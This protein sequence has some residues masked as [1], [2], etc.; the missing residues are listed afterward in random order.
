MRQDMITI[1]GLSRRLASVIRVHLVQIGSSVPKMVAAMP[2]DSTGRAYSYRAVTRKLAGEARITL[3]DLEAFCVGL[4]VE[5]EV[6]L[7][8]AAEYDEIGAAA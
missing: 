3:D 6:L 5:P 2:A 1:G 8:A 4:G 7:T